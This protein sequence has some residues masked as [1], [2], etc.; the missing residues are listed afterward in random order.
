MQTVIEPFREL[1]NYHGRG[2]DYRSEE[3]FASPR[4]TLDNG[5][6]KFHADRDCGS[7]NV[8]FIEETS[9]SSTGE[10][11]SYNIYCGDC[12]HKI[13]EDEILFVGGQWYRENGWQGYGRPIEDLHL[14]EHRVLSLGPQPSED[15][16]THALNLTRI[17][18][19]A[20]A[21]G[22]SFGHE[23]Y[24]ECD[25]CGHETFLLYDDDCRMCYDGEW[26]ERM[27]ETLLSVE[28]SIRVQNNSFVHRLPD[29]I[30]PL[31][32]HNRLFEDKVLWRYT[33][34]D[35]LPKIAVVTKCFENRN[36]GDNEYVLTNKDGSD[37]WLIHQ[38]E[39][40]DVFWDTGLNLTDEDKATDMDE[41][42]LALKFLP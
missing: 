4:R 17:E 13:P 7:N 9:H 20:S 36:T 41:L 28:N 22:I 29:H 25:T 38:N 8:R 12:G 33:P 32:I 37:T 24:N 35:D 10:R 2:K 16:L 6:Q 30:D 15:E 39:V 42:Q 21:L 18:G 26:T 23:S 11:W 34:H 31:S 14:P 19:N 1:N 27:Q 40:E 3:V 5:W